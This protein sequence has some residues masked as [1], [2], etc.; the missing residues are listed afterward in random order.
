MSNV[1]VKWSVTQW[2]QVIAGI[3][4]LWK[5]LVQMI[6]AIEAAGGDGETKKAAVMEWLTILI[7]TADDYVPGLPGLKEF[8]LA[9]ADKIIDAIVATWNK[10][11]KFVHKAEA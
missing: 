10:V 1:K 4:M 3:G 5:G 9:A 8:I 6:E 7:D 2:L 11:G